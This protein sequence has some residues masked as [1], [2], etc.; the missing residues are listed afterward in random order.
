MIKFTP[1]T[2]GEI[3][4]NFMINETSYLSFRQFPPFRTWEKTDVKNETEV[5][6]ILKFKLAMP[7][8]KI[9][10]LLSHGVDSLVLASAMP[11]GSF[12]YT[13]RFDGNVPDESSEAKR[14]A[15]MLGLKH[16]TIFINWEDHL[17]Y[18]PDLIK[19]RKQPLMGT[20]PTVYKLALEAKKDG[21]ETLVTGTSTEYT[22]AGK[23]F[24]KYMKY[25]YD[26]NRFLKEISGNRPIKW[27][28][29]SSS[30]WDLAIDF[31]DKNDRIS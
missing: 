17:K 3:Q 30:L 19:Y 7:K 25:Q 2:T 8:D 13:A 24:L 18:I 15:D 1:G 4:R 28:R 23:A 16:R 9:G 5:Y 27:L 11:K 12:A 14:F 29:Q 21:V 6:D 20:E 22:F 26:T 10:I 31:I